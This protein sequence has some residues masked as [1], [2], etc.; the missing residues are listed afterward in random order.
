M[1]KASF[2][3]IGGLLMALIGYSLAKQDYTAGDWLWFALHVILTWW[4]IWIF[5]NGYNNLPKR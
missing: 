3:T 5:A 2:D 1:T 4:G